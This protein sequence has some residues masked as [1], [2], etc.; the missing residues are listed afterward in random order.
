MCIVTQTDQLIL[1]VSAPPLAL[2]LM[3]FL[4]ICWNTIDRPRSASVPLLTAL[5]SDGALSFIVRVSSTVRV[6]GIEYSRAVQIITAIRALHVV[7]ITTG[8]PGETMLGVIMLSITSTV[9]AT[10]NLR[11]L[12]RKLERSRAVP[13]RAKMGASLVSLPHSRSQWEAG[14]SIEIGQVGIDVELRKD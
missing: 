3:L 13:N 8:D 12:G 6:P 5:A 11:L 2:E 14:E 4:V 7:L 10:F 9:S 1:A